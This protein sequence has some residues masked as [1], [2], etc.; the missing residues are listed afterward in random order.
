MENPV[1]RN[2][3]LD[4]V[5]WSIHNYQKTF[6]LSKYVGGFIRYNKYGR[7]DVCRILNWPSDISSTVYGY[8]TNNE[9]T[10]CFVTYHKSSDIN[11]NTNYNDHFID[12]NTFAWESRSNR[13]V[14]SIEIQNVIKSKR[15]LLFIKKED[16]EGSDFYFMG[17]VKIVE[18]S[19]KQSKMANSE[20]P[21]VHFKFSLDHPVED[22]IYDY[23]T[24]KPDV[25]NEYI[26]PIT[27][28]EETSPP[29]RILS[30]NEVKPF[31]NCIPLYDI[32]AAAGDFSDL[33][34]NEE[35]EWIKLNK[36]FNY[37]EDYFVCKVIG[38]SM[39]KV[40]PNNSWC[41]FRKD[42][43]G[44]RNGAIV[45]VHQS[46]FKDSDFGNGYTVK[47]YESNKTVSEEGY[48]HN[49]IILKP[50]S[51]NPKFKN[52][53]LDDDASIEFKVVGLLVEILG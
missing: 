52:I 23:L 13:K 7:K 2:F 14:E 31:K 20:L 19:I 3:L 27:I 22:S 42:T 17:D 38:E 46:N 12:R 25:K 40:I 50:K 41:L 48:Q 30:R 24:Y 49:S 15:I 5:N 53:I 44:S 29:F 21:V 26:E 18:D 9:I 16:S 34:L 6:Q 8:R 37:S 32:K 39:N 4:G 10:P 51:E 11:D 28:D 35:T 36:D 1:F 45:L 43:G 47:Y 33:Q